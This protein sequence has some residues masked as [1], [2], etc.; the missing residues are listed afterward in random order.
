MRH[1][2]IMMYVHH[3]PIKDLSLFRLYMYHSLPPSLSIT[4]E[5]PPARARGMQEKKST[6]LNPGLTNGGNIPR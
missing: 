1:E 3:Q 4:W 2:E 6:F 5:L